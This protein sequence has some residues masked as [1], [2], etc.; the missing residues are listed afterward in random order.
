MKPDCDITTITLDRGVGSELFSPNNSSDFWCLPFGVSLPLRMDGVIAYSRAATG[1]DLRRKHNVTSP[2][3]ATSA[4]PDFAA[5]GGRSIHEGT[6]D[7]LR[8]L[9]VDQPLRDA[10]IFRL[11]EFLNDQREARHSWPGEMLFAT[12]RG[13]FEDG[14]ISNQEREE[15]GAQMIEIESRCPV[16]APNGA[17]TLKDRRLNLNPEHFRAPT[18][19]G[20]VEVHDE[21]AHTNYAA[22]LER[23][24]CTCPRWSR[25]RSRWP[26]SDARRC[27]QH[28]IEA[29]SREIHRGRDEGISP[30]VRFVMTDLAARA[31]E[32]EP[33]S[34]WYQLRVQLRPYVI[35]VESGSWY[36]VYGPDDA[37][38]IESF[39]FHPV[40]CRW[41][42][43]FHPLGAELLEEWM[44]S[45]N[46]TGGVPPT[47]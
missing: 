4:G 20:N 9:P 38:R 2:T 37:R 23:L 43:G 17:G 14:R 28:L 40:D 6:L 21:S 32:F 5:N 11:A 29:I 27:C 18:F 33:D 36:R 24:S 45:E 15:L 25:N 22:N 44:Q 42:Y 34:R 46:Q 31:R 30:I 13:I 26:S 7:L 41:A 3:Y 8:R 19:R 47:P 10:E 35:G 16:G 1:Y 12:L 39:A